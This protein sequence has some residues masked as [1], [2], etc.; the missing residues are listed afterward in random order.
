MIRDVEDVRIKKK[1]KKK[2]KDQSGAKDEKQSN[3]RI[4]EDG[5]IVEDL[6]AGNVDAKVASDGC[7]VAA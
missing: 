1:S 2:M 5:L 6:S 3:I 4:L 7:K